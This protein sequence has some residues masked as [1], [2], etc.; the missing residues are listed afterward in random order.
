MLMVLTT[1]FI[2]KKFR[3]FI[4]MKIQ[5]ASSL[6]GQFSRWLEYRFQYNVFLF[7]FPDIERIQQLYW[8]HRMK[9]MWTAEIQHLNEDMIV[10]V[11][12]AI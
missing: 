1:A 9:K 8:V 6:R 7:I 5:I 10:T 11:V 12:I 4:F 2:S 3:Y